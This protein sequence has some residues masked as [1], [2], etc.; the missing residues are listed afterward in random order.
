MLGFYILLLGAFSHYFKALG[1]SMGWIDWF[2]LIGSI[3]FIVIYGIYKSKKQADL[4]DY[5]LGNQ[6]TKWWKVG[7]AVM[8]TQNKCSYLYINNRSRL[9]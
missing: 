6:D 2:V 3:G 7:F 9:F 5:L 4:S 1:I 8:A